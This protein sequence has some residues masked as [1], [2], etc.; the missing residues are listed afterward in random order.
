MPYTKEELLNIYLNTKKEQPKVEETPIETVEKPIQSEPKPN[1][2]S[3][4]TGTIPSLTEPA[5]QETIA[6]GIVRTLGT[7]WDIGGVASGLYPIGNVLKLQSDVLVGNKQ[8]PKSII[9][10]TAREGKA[11]W[12]GLT[13]K[14]KNTVGD[15]LNVFTTKV[16]DQYWFLKGAMLTGTQYVGQALDPRWYLLGNVASK[17]AEPITKPIGKLVG[18]IGEK[19]IKKYPVLAEDIKLPSI[20]KILPKEQSVQKMKPEVVDDIIRGAAAG[21]KEA[22][23]VVTHSLLKNQDIE[24]V[25]PNISKQTTIN[26]NKVDNMDDVGNIVARHYDDIS[27]LPTEDA[28]NRIAPKIELYCKQ[29]NKPLTCISLDIND[30]G[31]LNQA[32]AAVFKKPIE[33][34]TQQELSEAMKYTDD[35][36]GQMSKFIQQKTKGS[37]AWF[38]YAGRRDEFFGVTTLK[39]VQVRDLLDDVN[40]QL[41]NTVFKSKA[42]LPFI[43]RSFGAGVEQMKSTAGAINQGKAIAWA[44]IGN[45]KNT[46]NFRQLSELKKATYITNDIIVNGEKLSTAFP[47]IMPPNPQSKLRETAYGYIMI[48]KLQMNADDMGYF[49]T[50]NY[51]EIYKVIDNGGMSIDDMAQ[52]IANMA[53]ND[54][55]KTAIPVKNMPL[56]YNQLV[57]EEYAVKSNWLKDAEDWLAQKYPG[58][59]PTEL[60]AGIPIWNEI[61]KANTWAGTKLKGAALKAYDK[62]DD[63]FKETA[64][65]S[66]E[67][68]KTTGLPTTLKTDRA[69]W[70]SVK[71]LFG[72][73]EG[74]NKFVGLRNAAQQELWDSNR[75]MYESKTMKKLFSLPE[76]VR[77]GVLAIGEGRASPTALFPQ[78]GLEVL[79]ELSAMGRER[80]MALI[81]LAE[82]YGFKFDEKVA[83][84]RRFQALMKISGESIETLKSQ[85]FDPTYFSHYHDKYFKEFAGKYIKYPVRRWKPGFLKKSQGIAGYIDD[86]G[87]TVP[88]QNQEFTEYKIRMKLIDDV[89]RTIGKPVPATGELLPGHVVYEPSGHF[90][91]YPITSED[92]KTAIALTTKNVEK[93][94][95]PI[96]VK[97]EMDSFLGRAGGLEKLLQKSY[98]KITNTWKM[99]VLA[100]SPRW[101]A[102][103]T[104]GNLTLNTLGEVSPNGYKNT[105][106]LFY[107]AGQIA[108]KEDI[109]FISAL[110][111]LNVPSAVTSGLYEGETGAAMRNIGVGR[112]GVKTTLRKIG[113]FAGWLPSKMYN[114]NSKVESFFRTANYID[115]IAKGASKADAINHVN[116]FLFNYQNLSWAERSIIRR[117]CPFYA[118]TKNISR[119]ALTYPIENPVYTAIGVGAAWYLTDYLRD[120]HGVLVDWDKNEVKIPN[121]DDDTYLVFKTRGMNPFTDIVTPFDLLSDDGLTKTLSKVNPILKV[122]IERATRTQVMPWGAQDWSAPVLR[123]DEYGREVRAIPPAWRHVALQF[124]QYSLYEQIKMPLSTYSATGEPII[125][126]RGK[127]YPRN[128][129]LDIIRMMGA[130]ISFE[131]ISESEINKLRKEYNDIRFEFES[132]KYKTR[133][134]IVIDNWQQ[135]LNDTEQDT[136]AQQ[137]Q[138]KQY[139]KD[140]L[141]KIYRGN[142]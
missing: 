134:E 82:Q 98:D 32:H 14:E 26:L 140:E 104:M 27:G 81:R 28:L 24:S 55:Y 115:Q 57:T 10:S 33:N 110:E 97:R 90:N 20:G 16:P 88:I 142:R 42:N 107:R 109:S 120:N 108:K 100:L 87:L 127:I 21:T 71:E 39:D 3:L 65:I 54:G 133:K 101:V 129:I 7:M 36:M 124:P 52:S 114:L 64:N 29:T 63:A 126:K 69:E 18:K 46:A 86:P 8:P 9:E 58:G 99:S 76:D 135:L 61:K 77:K 95:V 85:G 125:S 1:Y 78:K 80:E 73:A 2:A 60:H 49:L 131:N 74:Q 47:D 105:V 72:K 138:R 43:G 96:A 34:L 13:L 70:A 31:A 103:N 116:K 139:T 15:A 30:A 92:G 53:H 6:Q 51:K 19:I 79:D 48:D 118:W 12:D 112:M 66:D 56:P 121:V 123:K 40:V 106:R 113:D 91:F 17:L 22:D 11:I 94:Q 75:R 5:Q 83:E 59:K 44:R 119:L 130:N 136:S 132:E 35:I 67:L 117:I 37:I 84:A 102:Y 128:T 23:D 122:G 41:Q 45:A 50:K 62:V 68:S 111:R 141:L 93:F 89:K 25:F 137:P 38:K 4:M